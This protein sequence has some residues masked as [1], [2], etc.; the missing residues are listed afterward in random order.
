EATEREPPQTL[1]RE[2]PGRPHPRQRFFDVGPRGVL[3]Q[4]RPETHFEGG[5]SRPPTQVAEP[6]EEEAVDAE[7]VLASPPSSRPYRAP[8]GAPTITPDGVSGRADIDSRA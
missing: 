3:C 2:T 5:V 7:Q 8:H 1:E 6:P 4:D